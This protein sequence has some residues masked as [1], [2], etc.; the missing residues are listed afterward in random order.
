[1]EAKNLMINSVNVIDSDLQNVTNFAICPI[2]PCDIV[3]ENGSLLVKAEDS[4]HRAVEAQRTLKFTQ[5]R[6]MR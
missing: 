1:M 6:S 5:R 2:I 3:G 4:G